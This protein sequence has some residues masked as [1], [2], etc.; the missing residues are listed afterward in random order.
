MRANLRAAAL[1]GWSDRVQAQSRQSCCAASAR[2]LRWWTRKQL[3]HLVSVV[4]VA[5]RVVCADRP[6]AVAS[7]SDQQFDEGEIS[8]G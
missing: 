5:N 3:V 7:V 1:L 4:G 6:L 8:A 2:R